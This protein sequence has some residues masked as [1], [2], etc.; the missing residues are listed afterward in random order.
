MA[1]YKL[2]WV[3]GSSGGIGSSGL[4]S[5]NKICD[6]MCLFD[7]TKLGLKDN[8]NF[9]LTD[10]SNQSQVKLVTKKAY[11]K[12]GNPEALLI[13]IGQVVS[14]D[15]I[16]TS[17]DEILSLFQNNYLAIIN[18]LRSFYEYCD[19]SIEI[20]KSILIISSNASVRA[21]P[22]QIVYASLKAAINSLVTSLAKDWGKYNIRIN[23]IA[24]GTVIVPRNIKLIKSKFLN[25]PHDFERPISKLMYPKNLQSTISYL[26]KKD[27]PITGQIVTI[28]G[29][30]T[31]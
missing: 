29:G 12:F 28:D 7:K 31:L 1:N 23:A 2:G 5:L 11:S 21:R 16:S 20:E 10:F 27:V 8:Q 18:S 6:K 9:W 19:K 25:F 14:K 13:A 4:K 26:F 24:P 3:I 30:S 22:N 15:F 17:N